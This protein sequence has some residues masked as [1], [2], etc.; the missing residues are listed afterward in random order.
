LLPDEGLPTAS[1]NSRP[2]SS[3]WQ[4][5]PIP[6]P[7]LPDNG[8]SVQAVAVQ[9]SPRG[10]TP[11]WGRQCSQDKQHHA[12]AV[13][14]IVVSSNCQGVARLQAVQLLGHQ[15]QGLIDG[16]FATESTTCYS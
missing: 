8:F 12:W 11:R 15:I 4:Y 3:G 1:P 6:Q 9:E 7:A 16:S 13:P 2:S 14:W 10:A 5:R